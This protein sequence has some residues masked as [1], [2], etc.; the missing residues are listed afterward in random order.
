MLLYLRYNEFYQSKKYPKDQIRRR[1]K[2][3]C[4]IISEYLIS[5]SLHRWWLSTVTVVL[6]D[7]A[8]FA[9]VPEG[10]SRPDVTRGDSLLLQASRLWWT[11]ALNWQT[12]LEVRLSPLMQL[13]I[14]LHILISRV[15]SMLRCYI[16][17]NIYKY[18]NSAMSWTT[19]I[20][21]W[22]PMTEDLKLLR[23]T[24]KQ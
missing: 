6:Y 7:T 20:H 1:P 18:C 11:H 17:H 14:R 2:W 3:L 19:A 22:N 4:I 9:K 21:L 16:Y 13:E 5:E 15:S 24:Y 8:F 12:A 10:T 23:C